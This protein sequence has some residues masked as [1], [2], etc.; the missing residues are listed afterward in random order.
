MSAPVC[1]TLILLNYLNGRIN[2]GTRNQGHIT[3]PVSNRFDY[4]IGYFISPNHELHRRSQI[5][6]R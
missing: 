5:G 3:K 1:I 6:S 4:E 2:N